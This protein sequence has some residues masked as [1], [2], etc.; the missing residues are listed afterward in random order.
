[1]PYNVDAPRKVNF[2]IV[3]KLDLSNARGTGGTFAF[4]PDRF[5]PAFVHAAPPTKIRL[6]AMP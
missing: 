3:P 6:G 4:R 2:S 1:M 5:F